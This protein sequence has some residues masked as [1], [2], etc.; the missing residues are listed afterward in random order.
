MIGLES[1][2]S[3]IIYHN[4]GTQ[5]EPHRDGLHRKDHAQSVLKVCQVQP[6][7]LEVHPASLADRALHV[8]SSEDR[9]YPRQAHSDP[10]AGLLHHLPARRRWQQLFPLLLTFRLLRC[11]LLSGK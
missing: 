7:S 2:L 4:E 8:P 6:V 1:T 5:V 11:V 9:I 3:L 10:G